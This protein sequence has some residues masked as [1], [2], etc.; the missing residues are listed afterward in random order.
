MIDNR[1][2]LEELKRTPLE[3]QRIELVERK[4]QGHPDSIY[5][6][7]AEAVSLA[8]C[9]GFQ[10]A[11]GRI[12]HHYTDKALLVAG[13]TLPRLGGGQVVEP[14]RLVLGDRAASGYQPA[15]G[16]AGR[17]VKP[18][19]SEA[20]RRCLARNLLIVTNPRSTMFSF[21]SK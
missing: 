21:H 10:V 8:L 2:L 7:V 4:G 18:R 17:S 5:D 9:R 6:A 11:F 19:A 20:R 12:L 15:R 14:M 16:E 13:R 3:Q 1:Y